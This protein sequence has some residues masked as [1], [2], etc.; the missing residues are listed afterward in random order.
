[1]P[2]RIIKKKEK[3]KLKQEEKSLTHNAIPGE[4]RLQQRIALPRQPAA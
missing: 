3:G 2:R 1:V 4:S